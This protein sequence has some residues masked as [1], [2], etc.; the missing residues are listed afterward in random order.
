MGVF[1]AFFGRFRVLAY[2]RAYTGEKSP[3]FSVLFS[4]SFPD[5][6]SNAKNGKKWQEKFFEKK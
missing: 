6:K 3:L 4:P 1:R 2:I 5:Q